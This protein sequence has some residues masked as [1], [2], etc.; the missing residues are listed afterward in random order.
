MLVVDSVCEFAHQKIFVRDLRSAGSESVVD[1]ILYSDR[2]H[3]VPL[4][5]LR[6]LDSFKNLA[7]NS[8]SFALVGR[9]PLSHDVSAIPFRLLAPAE[10]CGIRRVLIGE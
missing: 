4:K 9:L 2:L 3:G 1:F 7:V 8:N 5:S 6:Y 10:Q